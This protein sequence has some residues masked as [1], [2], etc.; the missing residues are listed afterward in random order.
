[1]MTKQDPLN[2]W[3]QQSG[4]IVFI[5]KDGLIRQCIKQDDRDAKVL[6][7]RIPIKR[8]TFRQRLWLGKG[9]DFLRDDENY[10]ERR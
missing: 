6:T 2:T 1:M 9:I 8:E 7:L 4:Y 3:R 5:D 10:G